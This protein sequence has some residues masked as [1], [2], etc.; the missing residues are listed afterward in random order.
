MAPGTARTLPELLATRVPGL[1]VER[2]SGAVGAGSRIRLRGANG[3]FFSNQPLVVVDG[4]R[5]IGDE[6]SLTIDVG[7]TAPSRLDDFDPEDVES[8]QVLSGPSAIARYGAA[9]TNGVIEIQTRRGEGRPTVRAFIATGIGTDPTSY[10]ANYAQ[11][12]VDRWGGRTIRCTLLEQADG[13]CIPKPDSLVSANPLKD[14]NP[15]RTGELRTVGVSVGGSVPLASYFVSGAADEDVG[16]V[17]PNRR[18]RKSFRGN[19]ALRPFAGV[20]L[21][22]TASHRRGWLDLPMD[23]ESRHSRLSNGLYAS[24]FDPTGPDGFPLPRSGVSEIASAQDF[25]HTTFGIRGDWQLLEWLSTGLSMGEDRTESSELQMVRN[26][27]LLAAEALTADENGRLRSIGVDL[28]TSF[29][30]RS[31]LEATSTLGWERVSDRRYAQRYVIRGGRVYKSGYREAIEEAFLRQQIA[32]GE[33]VTL[34]GSLRMDDPSMRSERN[35][36]LSSSLGLEWLAVRG[37]GSD[38][39]GVDEVRVFAG[40]GS[41]SSRG[42]LMGDT[43]WGICSESN[44]CIV[45]GSLRP[46]VTR[47]LE[48]G[49]GVVLL[50]GRVNVDLTAYDRETRDALGWSWGGIVDGGVDVLRNVGTVHNRGIEG[51]LNVELIT[52]SRVRWSADLIAAT[53]HNRLDAGGLS[54]SPRIGAGQSHLDGYPLG[55]YVGHRIVAVQDLNG[56]GLIGSATCSEGRCEIR[57]GDEPEFLG[58]STPSRVVALGNRLRLF[59]FAEVSARLEHQGGGQLLNLTKA[60]RC[61]T[62]MSCREA[63]ERDTPLETQA[64]IAAMGLGSYAGFIEDADVVKLRELSVTLS[65]PATLAHR[66]GATGLDFTL[67]GRNLATW[68]GYSGFDPEVNTYGQAPFRRA[69]SFVQPLTRQ[70]TTRLD[71]R[72]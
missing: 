53:N 15:F 58:S 49:L 9:G 57:L 43:E 70:W 47:D 71:V 7:G 27:D 25:R 52:R 31:G 5:Y 36:P 13:R 22:V 34:N 63:Y 46:E 4:V 19:L 39:L 12:G 14:A 24:P 65:A 41:I 69:D 17:D 61:S 26:R 18:E 3:M 60:T 56:D 68:T 44:I 23:G 66:V 2:S 6:R 45:K 8:I 21:K 48:M 35:S 29:S 55:G 54:L 37:V 20:E 62:A 32:W 59:G 38:G 10:P 33:R 67:A 72:F 28:T 16:V 51:S 50:R 42:R 40:Y 30:I 64:A 11:V 1:I